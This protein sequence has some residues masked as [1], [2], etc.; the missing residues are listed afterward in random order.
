METYFITLALVTKRYMIQNRRLSIMSCHLKSIIQRRI[1]PT[2]RQRSHL[3]LD[4]V[5]GKSDSVHNYNVM[6]QE[7]GVV[8]KLASLKTKSRVQMPI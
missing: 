6:S 4:S 7:I 3:K 1:T 5:I 8:R 2:W